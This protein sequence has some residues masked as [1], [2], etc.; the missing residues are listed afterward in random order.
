MTEPASSGVQYPAL[1]RLDRLLIL[2]LAVALFLLME[3]PLWRHLFDWDRTIGWSYAAVPLLVLAALALRHRLSWLAWFL[4]SLELVFWKFAVTAG[5]L[6]IVLG[7]V[8]PEVQ[9]AAPRSAQVPAAPPEKAALPLPPTAR[10]R[11][12]GRVLRA[13]MPATAGTLVFISSGLADCTW[14]VPAATLQLTNDG[15]G[16]EPALTAAQAGEKILASS[17]DHHLHTLLMTQAGSAW[18]LNAPVLASGDPTPIQPGDVQGIVDL[19]CAVHGAAEHASRLVLLRHPFY[20]SARGN[21]DFAFDGVPPGTVTLTA[22]EP[23]GG[24]AETVAI[25]RA[26]ETTHAELSL[27]GGQ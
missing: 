19:R 13:G 9:P 5:I 7:R 17:S 10:G 18:R 20:Q 2:A 25:V 11:L 6:L 15:H 24:R 22:L 1:S 14:P 3:G 26:G 8:T 27:T 21:G 23:D 4:H 12:E 16:F